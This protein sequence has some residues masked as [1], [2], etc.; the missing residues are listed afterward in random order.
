MTLEYKGHRIDALASPSN[1]GD[2][3]VEVT[4]IWTDGT[5]ER[6]RKFGPYQAFF[7]ATD[8]ESW[9]LLSGMEW[10]DIGKP[11]RLAAVTLPD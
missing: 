3:G 10:I 7:S 5:V 4:L 6:K 9:G 8:A 1:N 11:A 2:W